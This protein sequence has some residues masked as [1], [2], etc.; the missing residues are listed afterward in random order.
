MPIVIRLLM[1]IL[2]VCFL[3]K[4]AYIFLDFVMTLMLARLFMLSQTLPWNAIVSAI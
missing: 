4:F 1:Y 2:N 3:L